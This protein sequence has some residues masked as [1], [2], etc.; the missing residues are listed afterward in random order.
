MDASAGG[1]IL[2]ENG[3]LL[4][5]QEKLEIGAIAWAGVMFARKEFLGYLKR[6]DKDL[7]RDVFPRMRGMMR[8]VDH[9]DAYDIGRGV[10]HYEWFKRKFEGRGLQK[11]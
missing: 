2:D 4:S 10:E 7:A 5:F 11:A 6:E 1:I 8:I 9:V 3:D